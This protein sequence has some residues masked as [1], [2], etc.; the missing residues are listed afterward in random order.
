[1]SVGVIGSLSSDIVCGAPARPGGAVYYATRALT[2]AGASAHVVTRC[3]AGEAAW[4]FGALESFGLHVTSRPG[5][6]TTE[7]RFHYEGDHRVMEVTAIGDSWTA[8][9]VHS[10]ARTALGDA[11]WVHV[12]ALLRSDFSPQTLQALAPGRRLLLD[13]QGLVR[14]ADIG[15]LKRDADIDRTVFASLEVLKLNEDEATILAGGLQPDRLRTLGVPEVLLTLGSAGAV[16]V[17]RA[18]A[19]RISPVPLDGVV[20]PTGAGDSF[21]ACYLNARAQGA[22]PVEAARTASAVT[23]EILVRTS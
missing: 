11:E 9:D 3:G 22:D 20:D 23:A 12:G 15:P 17:T 6:R 13:G 21:S 10:W 14:R 5:V 4:L 18:H 8:E 19:E 1:M 16:V 2:H 7:F